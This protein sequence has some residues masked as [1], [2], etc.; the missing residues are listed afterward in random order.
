LGATDCF[1]CSCPGKTASG[2][3]S[4][5]RLQVEGGSTSEGGG[6]S[7]GDALIQHRQNTD[8]RMSKEERCHPEERRLRE[9]WI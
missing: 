9:V 4:A 1:C 6:T 5:V 2:D 8:D 7:V 3:S